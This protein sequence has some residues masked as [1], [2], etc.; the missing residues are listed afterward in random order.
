MADIEALEARVDDLRRQVR[1]AEQRV[2]EARHE[3][4]AA[5]R[6]LQGARRTEVAFRYRYV[7]SGRAKESEYLRVVLP[8][9]V[10]LLDAPAGWE[11]KTTRS[12][13]VRLGHLVGRDE[14]HEHVF[15]C[16]APLGLAREHL[17]WGQDGADPMALAPGFAPAPLPSGPV[18][19]GPPAFGPAPSAVPTGP[20][21]ATGAPPPG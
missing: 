11:V 20:A 12:G 13:R 10:A 21:V 3:L 14:P 5:E 4:H 16:A 1:D 15:R 9:G 6:E 8:R 17:S 2:H 18:P 19:T 7:V